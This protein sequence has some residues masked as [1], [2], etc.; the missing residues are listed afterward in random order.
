MVP[1]HLVK[2]TPEELELIASRMQRMQDRLDMPIE[3]VR[4]SKGYIA[5][6]DGNIGCGTTQ[7]EAESDLWE[8]ENRDAVNRSW[9][10]K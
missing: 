9:D 1:W 2:H 6:R 3:F 4:T 10:E 5:R 7:D 8:K